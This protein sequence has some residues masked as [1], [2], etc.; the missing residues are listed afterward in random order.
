M[1]WYTYIK[2]K[3]DFC[4]G[5]TLER[6]DAEI[7]SS[8]R[9]IEEKRAL[10]KGYMIRAYYENNFRNDLITYNCIKAKIDEIYTYEKMEVL[11][12]YKRN[13]LSKDKYFYEDTG[14]LVFNHIDT[15]QNVENNDEY[16]DRITFDMFIL[17]CVKFNKND[18]EDNTEMD[19]LR[20]SYQNEIDELIDNLLETADDAALATLIED[21]EEVL[22]ED[23]YYEKYSKKEEK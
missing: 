6:L 18:V 12:T 17:S 8:T 22:G 3:K 19:Y 23:K 14:H 10:L 15:N 9:I 4:S 13:I 16:K 1:S 20:Y 7:D 5:C 21:A 11:D 2:P